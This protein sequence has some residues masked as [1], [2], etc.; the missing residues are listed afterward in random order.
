MDT[1]PASPGAAE[2]R[3]TALPRLDR[4]VIAASLAGLVGLA[5]LYLWLDAA[6]M[7][8]MGGA[9]AM[10]RDPFAP[11]ALALAFLMWAVMMAGMMLPSALPAILMFAGLV[12]KHRAAGSAAP[13][14]WLFT[15]GYL[16]VWTAFS[17]VAAVLQ[18]G[19]EQARLITPMLVSA[20]AW[21][22]G[23]LMVLAGLYQ[24]SA[25]KEV[26]LRKCRAPVQFFMFHWRPG[27][28]GAVAMGAEH[29]MFCLGCCWALMLLLFVAGVMNLI[30]VAV[31][32]GVVLVEKLMPG[33]PLAGR[34][35]GVVLVAGGAAVAAGLV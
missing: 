4:L 21:L 14:A 35:L 17:L 3:A 6:A 29:G 12:R 16:L 2:A 13:P 15:L 19:L 20:S 26:C 27:A 32:A 33:G 25:L 23:G 31:I 22:T 10:A 34:V 9:M 30:W 7:A 8:D 5:W 24:F 18:A 11:G 28:G 1:S